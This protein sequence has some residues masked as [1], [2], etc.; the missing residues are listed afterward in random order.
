MWFVDVSTKT[1]W[2]DSATVLTVGAVAL[3][4]ELVIFNRIVDYFRPAD[5]L[6]DVSDI[7][8]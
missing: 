6:A 1:E 2:H 4:V 3:V 5:E 8:S 7:S